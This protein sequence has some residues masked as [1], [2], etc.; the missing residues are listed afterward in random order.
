MRA[1]LF[2][3]GSGRFD[4]GQQI[5]SRAAYMDFNGCFFA[6]MSLSL[7]GSNTVSGKLQ[8][9][10]YERD[11]AVVFMKLAADHAAYVFAN[12]AFDDIMACW[13]IRYSS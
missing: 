7:Y 2:K 6:K 3:H 12:S 13:W 8:V 9:P 11:L 5:R 4:I 1:V 10:I